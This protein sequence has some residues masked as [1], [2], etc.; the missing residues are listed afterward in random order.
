MHYR[1]LP[2][3]LKPLADTFYRSQRSA[4][5]A[6]AGAQLWVAE[7]QEIVAAL[8]LHKVEYGH[9]LT[10]LLVATP[11]RRQGVARQLIATALTDCVTPVWLF[12]DPQLSDFYLRLGFTPCTD[13]PQPLAERL[14]RYQRR[15]SLLALSRSP[16]AHQDK[17]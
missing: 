13:L 6:T 9:W 5:R 2:A 3:P 7:D 15:K 11:L 12:C 1:L 14:A 16:C 10:S 17:S 4:M 8:C